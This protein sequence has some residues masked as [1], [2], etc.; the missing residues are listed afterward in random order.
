MS[1]SQ[2]LSILLARKWIFV[3]VFSITV[4]VTTVVS[5]LLPK[6]YSATASL[7]LNSKGADPVTGFMLPATLMPG[8]IA[9]QV[10]IIQSRNV[11]LK[12]VDKLGIANNAT[13]KAQF[14]K[15]TQGEGDIRHW[16]ADQFIEN[17][18]V[19]PSLQS[20]VIEVSYRGADP[21]FSAAMAN[22]FAEAYIDTSL[23]LKIEPAKQ[24][25][26][27]FDQQI[28]GLRQNVE[29]AQT[30][31]SAYQQENGI[32]FADERLDT[33]AA[34]LGELSSQLVAAQ[35]QTFDSNSRQNQ[36]KRGNAG[37]SPEILSNSLIQGL[38]SQLAQAETKLSDVSQRLGVN[39][40]QYQA[41]VAE[42]SNLRSLISVETA[43][44][45]SSVGQTA[46]VSQQREG[47]IKASLAQQKER[48]LKLKDQHD[49][50]A[51]LVREVESA[52]RMYDNALL[53]FGQTNMESQSGQTDVSILNPATPP[54]KH[55]S[56]KITIN[57]VLSILLGSL[58]AVGFAIAAE[59]LDRR[60]RIAEDLVQLLGLPVLGVISQ[61]QKKAAGFLTTLHEFFSKKNKVKNT[62][63]T[64]PFFV[65]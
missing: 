20:S 10:D 54:I 29:Q 8:Y 27:W 24:A 25:A 18:E 64:H 36:L 6:T 15:A 16:F 57:I 31:L 45:S 59:M 42:V 11:A 44:T 4:L 56:P 21:Q 22:A 32:A 1:F 19:N 43:K 38:K 52:Q 14:E 61:N 41:V 34:R 60:V 3:W 5:F 23:Q 26:L 53:R 62:N 49:Q 55:S 51:V 17:L 28:K 9:T 63:P 39:H 50:M 48:V 35:A 13:A 65:K 46:R 40:P 30:K 7:V 47:E 2:L 12:V 37:E 33:E 58:L